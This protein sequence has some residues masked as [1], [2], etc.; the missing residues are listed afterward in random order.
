LK[1]PLLVA[2]QRLL[3]FFHFWAE[4]HYIIRKSNSKRKGILDRRINHLFTISF[5]TGGDIE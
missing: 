4:F 5:S 3:W 1:L 2:I